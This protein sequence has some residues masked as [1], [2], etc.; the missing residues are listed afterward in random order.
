MPNGE[1]NQAEIRGRIAAIRASIAVTRGDLPRTIA[2]S[3]LALEYLPKENISRAYAAWYLG[4]AYWL[5]GDMSAASIALAE[6]SHVSW[7]VDH[8][9]TVFMVAHDLAHVQKLQG[10]LHQADSTY[11]QALQQALER[12]GHQP[13]VGPAY[14]G[15][16]NLQYEWNHLDAAT[17][18]LQE[19]IQ[20]CEQTGNGRA[21]LQAH[22]TLAFIKQA[23]G[24]ADGA[25]AIMRQTVQIT[26]RQRL[27]Q[28]RNAQVEASQAWL[29]L[30]QG[31]E[32]TVL[33]WLQHC[34]LSLEQKLTHLREREYLTLVRVLIMQRRL[35][36]AMKWLESLLQLAEAQGRMGS[37]IELLMLQAEALQASGEVKQALERLTQVISLAEPE[38]YI[39]LFVDEGVP[40]AHLLIQMRNRQH[41]GQR[42]TRDRFPLDYIKKLLAA[43]GT[44]SS[45]SVP[46]PPELTPV[47]VSHTLV[48][49]LSERELE[50]LR[51]IVA[52]C[53]NQEIA[54]RLVIAL[55]TVKWYINAI[56][57]KLQVESRTKAIARARELHI[58]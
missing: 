39:R 38:G 3:R 55:S 21:I 32:A 19:G 29:S 54:D 20:L 56:Y 9:Y 27:S 57:G 7:E 31:D 46:Q 10:H 23:Q 42:S 41:A 47:S 12:G 52:G 13:A 24:D 53:S 11:R 4:R 51:L 40:M 14:V 22:I 5:S 6:A 33:R 45:Q 48:E 17:S 18:L 49:P 26:E 30:M 50:V 43:F 2:L 1:F 37:V 44:T 36:E 35:D 8:L 28:H 25:S 58:V 16:G 15:R 34:G